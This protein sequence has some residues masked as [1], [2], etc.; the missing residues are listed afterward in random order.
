VTATTLED[1]SRREDVS[2][3][4]MLRRAG[5]I[6]WSQPL[7]FAPLAL[8]YIVSRAPFLA[9]SY[10]TDPDA[11]RIALSGLW[12]WDH[13]EFYPSRLPGYPVVELANAAVIKGGPLAT[14]SLTLVVSLVGVWFFARIAERLALP[15]RGMV[16]PAFAFTPLLWINSMT[17]MDYMWALTFILGAYL[18]LLRRSSVLAG[19]MLGLAIGSRATSAFM[20]LPL[21]A[22]MW[23]DGRHSEIRPF[24]VSAIAVSLAAFAPI[25]WK[26]EIGF[27]NF[28]DSEVGYKAVLRLLAK[29][30][31]GLTG[32]A[33][34]AVAAAL[35]LPR[36]LRLPADVFRDKN[37]M[38][39]ALAIAVTG[40]SFARLPHEAAY[41]I[42]IYPF[43]F[44][45]MARYFRPAALAGTL[46]VIVLAGFIDLTS[47]GEEISASALLDARP[48]RGLVLS[49]DETMRKQIEFADDV[50]S[51]GATSNNTIVA[52]GFVYPI[53]V[54]R[55]YDELN[56]GKL[57]EDESAISQ[58]SDKG[59]AEDPRRGITY[60]WLLDFDSFSDFREREATFMYTP[61]AVRST[62]ALYE[63]RPGLYGAALIDLGRG[64]SGGSGAART[65]R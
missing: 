2:T 37:V 23:R 60:V 15:H 39:W 49:N 7:A 54:V 16:V 65:D 26:Y 10:G 46:A 31:L 4:A 29:D 38:V 8:A 33:A 58:L 43:A 40:M 1:V 18:C 24:V 56:V 25:Y 61:D 27:L 47:P 20:V 57:E 3:A 45:I 9:T 53:F 28:Y 5:A 32:A 41:L 64:P 14:N 55:N 42:P 59:K 6:D 52:L 62:A 30:C 50:K 12:L 21:L 19:L 22:Y 34:V 48:G 13:H 44:F 51:I 36:L 17:T 63:Y 11:W 35:S